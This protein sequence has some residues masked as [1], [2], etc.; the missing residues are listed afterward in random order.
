[1]KRM[2][3]GR[4]N[5]EV[6]VLLHGG[7][8]SWWNFR[9]EAELLGDRFH[10]VLPTLDGHAAS[11]ADF[12]S[13]EANADRIISYIDRQF[14][15]HVLMMG[16]LS[17]G[18]Q[19]LVEILTR[20]PD[21]CRY[22]V[23]ESA[24]VIPSKLTAAAVGP[25]CGTCYGLIKKDWFAKMQF[26]S[27]RIREDLFEE[28]FRD[29]AVIA[30]PNLIA[31]LKASAAYG[32]K[33]DLPTSGDGIRIIVGEKESGRI[34]KSARLL[35]DMLPGSRLEVKEGLYHGEYSLNLPERYVKDL[36]AW[37]PQKERT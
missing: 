37:L 14:G 11:D 6:L 4:D 5:K 26:R 31:F 18:A 22:A 30:K 2:E 23:V 25:T 13:I 27:L 28:Y 17:L 8:L 32:L 29:T 19:V 36:V 12:V 15:G 33:Q 24:S 1:M 3:Y 16:G 35:H 10:V 21:I 20:R 7:G 34:L 9:K